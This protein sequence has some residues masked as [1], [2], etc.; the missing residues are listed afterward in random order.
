M[1]NKYAPD[2]LIDGMYKEIEKQQRTLQLIQKQQMIPTLPIYNNAYFPMAKGTETG[3]KLVGTHGQIVRDSF[4]NYFGF[5]MPNWMWVFGEDDQWHQVSVIHR[6]R[7]RDTFDIAPVAIPIDGNVNNA[8]KVP[9]NVTYTSDPSIMDFIPD[10]AGHRIRIKSGG[11][12]SAFYRVWPEDDNTQPV[13][14]FGYEWAEAYVTI[15]GI[16]G[17]P[18][19]K[20][21][22]GVGNGCH[23]GCDFVVPE[24]P[25]GVELYTTVRMAAATASV[26]WPRWYTMDLDLYADFHN[27]PDLHDNFNNNYLEVWRLGHV[28]NDDITVPDP[29]EGEG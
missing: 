6:A 18:F 16:P 22:R 19:Q 11:Y 4:V 23:G 17:G 29:H 20:W 14:H 2:N 3:D 27:D 1:K 5:T 12:Y 21:I 8:V 24:N 26:V 15:H 28:D 10:G 7:M 25:E 13:T 9:M